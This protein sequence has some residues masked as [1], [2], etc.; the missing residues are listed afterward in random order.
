MVT[1]KC[2][3]C[4]VFVEIPP[5]FLG[6]QVGCIG[7]KHIYILSKQYHDIRYKQMVI[8]NT[9]LFTLL[10]A[11]IFIKI[12]HDYSLI[13]TPIK[14]AYVTVTDK[15]KEVFAKPTPAGELLF[16]DF[17]SAYGT[18]AD[19]LKRK[20]PIVLPEH[21]GRIIE[22]QGEISQIGALEDHPYGSFYIRFKQSFAATSNVTAYFREDQ[23]QSLKDVQV[24]HYETYRGVIVSAGY[25]EIDH[26]LKQGEILK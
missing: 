8:I 1:V 20:K 19:K 13:G 26:I 7:C 4:S 2:P 14:S 17:D 12:E 15:Y 23:A 11:G 3:N 10:I 5:E 21:K 25:G 6:K 18:K 16:F 24:G 9:I 22:W